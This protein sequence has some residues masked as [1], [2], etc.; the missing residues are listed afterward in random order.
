MENEQTINTSSKQQGS[1]RTLTVRINPPPNPDWECDC[2]GKSISEL[3]PFRLEWNPKAGAFDA[4][5]LGRQLRRL[6]PY[7]EEAER[8]FTEFHWVGETEEDCLKA[9]EKLIEKYGKE[10]ADKVSFAIQASR[11]FDKSWECKDCLGLDEKEYFER[12]SERH[13]NEKLK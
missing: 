13:K 3:E 5:Y 1:I 10:K 6:S 11:S 4:Q 2:C 8:I 9:D 7:N 12:C